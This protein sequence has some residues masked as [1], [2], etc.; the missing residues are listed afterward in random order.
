[1]GL[2]GG[3][4]WTH[5]NCCLRS[6]ISSLS[7]THCLSLVSFLSISIWEPT[8]KA[9]FTHQPLRHHFWGAW[10]ATSVFFFQ[11]KPLE[12][13]EISLIFF[14]SL[15]V[16]GRGS[17][18]PGQRASVE[19]A[20]KNRKVDQSSTWS[21][22]ATGKA[23]IARENKS[24]LVVLEKQ[25]ILVRKINC[26]Y[27]LLYPSEWAVARVLSYFLSLKGQAI[28]FFLQDP[29]CLHFRAQEK[30]WGIREWAD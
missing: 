24:H 21:E 27:G 30:V 7:P 20:V 12:S 13:R 4:I 2:Y 3:I 18:L 9:S 17:G 5:K 16:W 10:I 26:Y 14:L 1:M 6:S 28:I 19:F 22:E 25:R 15:Y 23:D 8:F 11:G 29:L